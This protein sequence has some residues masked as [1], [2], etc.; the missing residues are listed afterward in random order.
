MY[1]FRD[2]SACFLHVIRDKIAYIF[3]DFIRFDSDGSSNAS[4]HDGDK[5]DGSNGNGF[6]FEKNSLIWVFQRTNPI[7][8]AF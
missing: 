2:I 8:T 7:F 3:E 6:I 4:G 5:E 1:L